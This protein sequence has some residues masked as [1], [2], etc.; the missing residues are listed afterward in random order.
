[1]LRDGR[2]LTGLGAGLMIGAM[3]VELLT[4]AAGAPGGAPAADAPFS[5]EAPPDP[6]RLAEE[7]RRLGLVLHDA[8][9]TWY[10]QEDVDALLEEAG[11]NGAAGSGAAGGPPDAGGAVEAVGPGE[12]PHF[13]LIEIRTG[14]T[15]D[16]VGRMLL[17]AGLVDDLDAWRREMAARGLEVRIRAGTYTFAY[18]PDLAALIDAITLQSGG[19]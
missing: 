3:L 17:A 14:M 9:K 19:R 11:R 8:A 5:A 2:F 4:A 6:D 1:V 18:K 10:S 7:A 15:S 13:Y 12:L 16:E